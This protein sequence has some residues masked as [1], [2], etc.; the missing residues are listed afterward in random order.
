[1][2]VAFK[3]PM[4]INLKSAV[5]IALVTVTGGLSFLP[6]AQAEEIKSSSEQ[7]IRYECYDRSG[8]ISYVTINPQE[9]IGWQMGCRE[10]PYISEAEA[11]SRATY[12]QCYD[13]VGN[14]ALTTTS[15]DVADAW[16]DCRKIGYRDSTPVRIQPVYYECLNSQGAVAF[17]TTR[18]QDTQG[19][20]PDCREVRTIT[21]A[22]APR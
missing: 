22:V 8:N 11:E 16:D 5:A 7:V 21:P 17:T 10:V 18:H 3:K 13:G 19:W 20:V 15:E 2:R 1:M 6:Y 4:M 14:I 9:T 12:Y